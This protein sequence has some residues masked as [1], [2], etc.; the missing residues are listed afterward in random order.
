M[1]MS[2]GYPIS[3]LDLINNS[4]E[5]EIYSKDRYYMSD[6]VKITIETLATTEEENTEETV[7]DTGSLLTGTEETTSEIN[8]DVGDITNSPFT[9]EVNDAYLYAYD[10]GITTK[11]TIQQ[12]DINGSLIR[13]HMAKMITNYALNVLGLTPDTSKDCEFT[14]IA[15]ETSEMQ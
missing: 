3:D 5:L 6:P 15:N 8:T 11:D 9:D 10:I 13:S 7:V 1:D 14:D 4:Y 2:S 12:A